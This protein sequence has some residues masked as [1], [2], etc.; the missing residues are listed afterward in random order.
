MTADLETRVRALGP[1]Y[2]SPI[3]SQA[4]GQIGIVSHWNCERLLF[5]AGGGGGQGASEIYR[6]KGTLQTG[7]GDVPWSVILKVLSVSLGV[8]EYQARSI[9]NPRREY[10]FF[11]SGISQQFPHRFRPAACYSYSIQFD[12]DRQ[13][14]YWL[15]LEDLT[16]LKI[17]QWGL[18][19]FAQAAQALG[20]LAG[21]FLSHQPLLRYDWMET[22]LIRK[23]LAVAEPKFHDLF[24]A[25]D[26]PLIQR[27]GF[28]PQVV[29]DLQEMWTRREE[30]FTLLERLPQT[31]C[32]GDANPTNLFLH[33]TA[34]G[35]VGVVAIDWATT[36]I[37]PIG[38][39]LAQLFLTG[40]NRFDQ[41]YT[42]ALDTALSKSY[43]EGLCMSG[44]EGDARLAR[45][46]YTSAMIKNR[47]SLVMW[48]TP[49]LTEP[50]SQERARHM[51]AAKGY[52]YEEGIE[53]T[54]WAQVY[55]GELFDESLRLRVQMI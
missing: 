20:M 29:A 2:L 11:A 14:E 33:S 37:G 1:L 45:L 34:E 18:E 43:L 25:R 42:R 40:I 13:E 53:K 10:D 23:Y 26:Q 8:L 5:T 48:I 28:T 4:A 51:F 39:D 30:H 12:A 38:Q 17:P 47:A 52:T 16:T 27:G 55:L 49:R 21:T 46:G 36:G 54:A 3:A 6:F 31:Y 19:Q 41:D 9:L 7:E 22:A 24:A 50:A 32:H 44:W 35:E 15:W